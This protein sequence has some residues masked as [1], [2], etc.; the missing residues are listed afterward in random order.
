V[1]IEPGLCSEPLLDRR[2]TVMKPRLRDR[3]SWTRISGLVIKDDS[4][5]AAAAPI[6]ELRRYKFH[7]GAREPLGEL[8]KRELVESQE[9]SGIKLIGQFRSLDDPDCFV[10]LR[11]FDDMATRLRALASSQNGPVSAGHGDEANAPIVDSEEVL[12]LRPAWPAS[13]F[14]LAAERPAPA[15]TGIAARLV[16]ATIYHL[17]SLTAH[18]FPALFE[19]V[20]VPTL[21]GTGASFLAAFVTAE[22]ANNFTRPPVRE[23]ERV[24]VSFSAFA[25]EDA[26]A[27]HEAGVAGSSAWRL[28]ELLLSSRTTRKPQTL[29]LV[30]TAR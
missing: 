12:L 30:P 21:I 8:F 27:L 23:T 9:A 2:V 14:A 15:A 20:V 16:V 18:D 29:R 5:L 3:P 17:N 24:L 11:R 25:S 10:L 13:G 6:V 1:L 19:S 4:K 22:M 28:L 7:P 26:Y